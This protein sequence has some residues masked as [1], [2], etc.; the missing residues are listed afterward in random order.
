MPVRLPSADPLAGGPSSRRLARPVVLGL[1]ACSAPAP[2]G[3]DSP[4]PAA[5]PAGAPP[6][7]A[8]APA[9][10]AARAPVADP[11]SL[12]AA[13][14][15]MDAVF[16]S[17]EAM[18][19]PRAIDPFFRVRGNEGYRKSTERILLLLREAGFTEGGSDAD[20]SRDTA[21]LRDLGPVEPAWTPLNGKLE[22]IAPDPLV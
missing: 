12:S 3:Q 11:T 1:A 17:A 19:L 2:S 22:I 14:S 6:A 7:A 15:A 4:P 5:P 18:K 20:L 16:D 8:A 9:A 10:P 21:E 13:V